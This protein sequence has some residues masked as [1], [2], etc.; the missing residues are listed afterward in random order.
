MF[1]PSDWN[2][3]FLKQ[4][5]EWPTN[6]CDFKSHKGPRKSNSASLIQQIHSTTCWKSTKPIAYI[7]WWQSRRFSHILVE[8]VGFVTN[9][10]KNLKIILGLI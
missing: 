9:L 3:R 7:C 1:G 6:R 10:K 2:I 8:G 4:E 5:H